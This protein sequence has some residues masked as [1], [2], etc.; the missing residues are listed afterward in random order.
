MAGLRNGEQF[1]EGRR[2]CR[3]AREGIEG[4]RVFVR[5]ARGHGEAIRRAAASVYA[6]QWVQRERP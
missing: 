4:A 1:V 2:S 5:H 6:L 3:W